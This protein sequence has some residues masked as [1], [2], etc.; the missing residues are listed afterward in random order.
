MFS[1]RYNGTTTA[2][3]MRAVR[4]RPSGFE[5]EFSRP[6]DTVVARST[7]SYTIQ[8]YHMTPT[9]AYGGGSKRGSTTLTPSQIRGDA[10]T[11]A[12]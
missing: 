2:F 4:A 8:S 6:V 7:A 5:I 3:E 11:R 1:V 10:A 12:Q 9:S